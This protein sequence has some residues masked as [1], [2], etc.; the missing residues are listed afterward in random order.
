VSEGDASWNAGYAAAAAAFSAAAA[1]A[2][3]P[4]LAQAH[5]VAHQVLL[6]NNMPPSGD[7]ADAAA[8]AHQYTYLPGADGT[9]QAIPAGARRPHCR[10]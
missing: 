10:V 4:P 6:A 8:A 7:G 9:L 3:S 2:L 5:Q 1:A